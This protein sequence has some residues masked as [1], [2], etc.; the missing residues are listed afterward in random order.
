MSRLRTPIRRQGAHVAKWSRWHDRSKLAVMRREG[1]SCAGCRSNMHPLEW[2]H[3]AGRGNI[4]SEPFASLPE[5]TAGLC[6]SSYGRVGCHDSID[7]GLNPDLLN[8]LRQ[9]AIVLLMVRFKELPMLRYDD[10]LDGIRDAV[11]QLENAGWMWDG[12]DLVKA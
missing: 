7:R 3:L 5:L 10:P 8:Q 6:V 2:A 11:R 4:I 12:R 1:F 9:R